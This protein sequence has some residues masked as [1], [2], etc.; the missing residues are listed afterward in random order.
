MAQERQEVRRAHEREVGVHHQDGAFGDEGET[1][2]DRGALA[3]ARVGEDRGAEL[4]S[5]LGRRGV[6]RDDG[7][8]ADR[9]AGREHVA[10][11]RERELRAGGRWQRCE[12]VLPARTPERHDDR[13]HR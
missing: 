4:C 10:E 7:R 2:G 6:V 11:H 8:S 5:E 3:A 13:H 1:G 9:S 12:A